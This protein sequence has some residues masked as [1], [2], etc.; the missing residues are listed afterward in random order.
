MQSAESSENEFFIGTITDIK[1][2]PRRWLVNLQVN[3]HDVK[4]KIDSGAESIHN[5]AVLQPTK[6]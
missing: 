1:D 3:G 5:P 6:S 4:F 2:D